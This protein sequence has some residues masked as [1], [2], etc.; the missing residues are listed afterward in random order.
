MAEWKDLKNRFFQY[1][2]THMA[3]WKNIKET[4]PL[5]FMPY[6][7]ERFYLQIGIRLT[8]LGTCT[9]WIK[10]GSFLHRW[11]CEQGRRAYWT[12]MNVS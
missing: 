11:V 7:E 12:V 1:L 6:L 3:E 2:F 9:Q 10:A 8:G 4:D 5:Q